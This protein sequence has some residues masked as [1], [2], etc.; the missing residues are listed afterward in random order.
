[1]VKV[2]A[3]QDWNVYGQ[4][5]G[6]EVSGSYSFSEARES[7]RSYSETREQTLMLIAEKPTTAYQKKIV[8]KFWDNDD[9]VIGL[10]IE[11]T[12]SP[13]QEPYDRRVLFNKDQSIASD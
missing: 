2:T 12:H 13:E 8:V 11:M 6:I 4:K 3:R 9:L 10:G 1:M 7:A 5:G